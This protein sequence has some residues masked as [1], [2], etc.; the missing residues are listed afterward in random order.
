MGFKIKPYYVCAGITTI[1]NS[2][3]SNTLIN[4]YIPLLS[5]LFFGRVLYNIDVNIHDNIPT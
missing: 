3:K 5:K 4:Y 1:I 2:R